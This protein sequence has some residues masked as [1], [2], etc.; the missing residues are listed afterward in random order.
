VGLAHA[1][2]QSALHLVQLCEIDMAEVWC[3][4]HSLQWSSKVSNQQYLQW[5]S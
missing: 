3:N 5:S 4:H 1:I 2:T